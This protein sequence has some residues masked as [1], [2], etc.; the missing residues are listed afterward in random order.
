MEL[1]KKPVDIF[2]IVITAVIILFFAQGTFAQES[3]VGIAIPVSLQ[4]SASEGDVICTVNEGY[5]LCRNSYDTSIFGV[6]SDNP[7]VNFDMSGVENSEM[8]LTSGKVRVNVSSINGAIAEG[9]FVTS[10]EKAGAAQRAD[11]NGYVLGTALESYQSGN[12]D[13][14]GKILVL[15]NIHPAVG[16]GTARTNL[17]Q[18]LRQGAGAAILEPLSSL[19]YLIAALVVI[20]AFIMGF[21][22]FSLVARSGIEA[23]GRNPL[24]SRI[25]QFNVMLHILISI[26]IV[27]IG[28]AIAYLI[29]IL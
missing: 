4:D 20:V 17:L 15:I 19:R 2:G 14:I 21:V 25:I 6:V 7:A 1:I 28:L 8:I 9:D 27:L 5:G 22:Y 10:S 11:R 23:I 24:A 29:L 18:L 3:A 16:L 13:S 26:I 12:P